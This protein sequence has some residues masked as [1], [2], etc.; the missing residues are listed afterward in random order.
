MKTRSLRLPDD[1]DAIATRFA[2]ERGMSI[3]DVILYAISR[4][5]NDTETDAIEKRLAAIRLLASGKV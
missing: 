1:I 2:A 5:A 3:N 4:L